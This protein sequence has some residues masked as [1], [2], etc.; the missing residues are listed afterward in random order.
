MPADKKK[1]LTPKARRDAE[2]LKDYIVERKLQGDRIQVT[3]LA[4]VWGVHRSVPGQYVNANIPLGNDWKMRFAKFLGVAPQR[5]WPDFVHK[6]VV[7]GDMPADVVAA[8]ERM[9]RMSDRERSA[10]VSYIL[11][12]PVSDGK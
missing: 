4:E 11:S 12:L 1:P 2:R 9:S 7:P 8:S 10:L 6:D 3:K 5:I